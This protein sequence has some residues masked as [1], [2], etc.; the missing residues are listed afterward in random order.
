MRAGSSWPTPAGSRSS[1]R[2][3]CTR[4]PTWP[5]KVTGYEIPGFFARKQAEEELRAAK[6]AAEHAARA[7][8]AFLAN[9]SHEIRTP[10][11]AVIGMTS[12]LADTELDPQQREFVETIRMS[13]EHLLGLINDILDFSKIEAGK[14][15]LEPQRFRLRSCIEEALELVAVKA[16]EK[17]LE[18][19]YQVDDG[20]P[21][22]LH[23]DSGR[24][25]QVLAN[26]LS[27]AVKFT[28]AGEVV[29]A[30]RGQ[31]TGRRPL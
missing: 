13:G 15:E 20:V 19:A 17:G 4:N 5:G 21:E 22:G 16:S 9:M 23:A 31:S 10:M 2:P 6:E 27:N 26:L 7:K 28:E 12:L 8:A 29:V 25:R 18:L 11:N 14:L 30:G 1:S 3:T 24:L